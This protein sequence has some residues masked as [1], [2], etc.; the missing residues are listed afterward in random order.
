MPVKITGMNSGLDTEQIVKDLVKAY[1]KKKE[2]YD[3]QLTKHQWTMD[4]WKETNTKVYGFYSSSLS[5]MR[6]SSDYALRKSTVS[7][8]N[9]ATVTAAANSVA[10]TQKLSVQ[11]LAT[12]GYLTGAKFTDDKGKT[13]GADTKLSDLGLTSGTI[14]LNG[15]DIEIDGDMSLTKLATAMKEKGVNANYDA[16]NGRFFISSK[17]SGAENEFTLTAKDADG[18][19]ALKKLG[20]YS[21][22]DSEKAEYAKFGTMSEEEATNAANALYLREFRAQMKSEYDTATA[23]AKAANESLKKLEELQKKL[24]DLKEDK[25]DTPEAFE[26]AKTKLNEQIAEYDE[27]ELRRT[28][29]E[30]T[31]L[32]ASK[33]EILDQK[34]EDLLAN[35]DPERLAEARNRINEQ[36]SFANSMAS[37]DDGA[38]KGASRIVGQDAIIFLNGAKFT[39]AT[40]SFSINGLT[41]EA[42]ATTDV[43]VDDDGEL[44]KDNSAVTISTAVDTQGIYDKIKN[45]LKSYNEMIRY[46]DGLYYADSAKGYEPLSD[47]EK[48]AMT[49]K[50]VEEWEKKVKD[51][52]LRRDSTLGN[53]SSAMKSAI[54]G[55]SY[56]DANG[57]K[58]SLASFGIAS[59]G[60]FTAD[61]K[62]R[63]TFHIDGD[64]DDAAVSGKTD[65]LMAAIASDPDAVVGF[66]QNMADSLYET[67]TKKMASSSVSS[68]FTIYND[69]Q[70]ASQYSDYKD[71]V[72]D[73]QK[74]IEDYEDYYTRKFT[75]ME[76]AMAKLQESTSALAGLLGGGQ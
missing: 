39:N 53:L 58:Y 3:K 69:K 14:S 71:Q 32:A 75:A 17:T 20:I 42:T 73:W 30:Q 47:D 61:Q 25:F 41:I 57:K 8:P 6:F 24:T 13:Y 23:Q 38:S 31:T 40:N 67:M 1:S 56:T 70:M 35:A 21:P 62:E 65:K 15:E 19:V 9:V 72:K 10:G 4:A 2:S 64:K 16:A 68:A 74:K 37:V 27:D 52:L 63:G 11:Q 5:A 18:L 7:N 34:D 29:D 48:E 22:T 46:V 59:S 26:E 76:K 12:S 54:L 51:A 49:D 55:A 66:F 60:Y 28:A 43:E 50:Q 44:V 33:K 45:F 36:M